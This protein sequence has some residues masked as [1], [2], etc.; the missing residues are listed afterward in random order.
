MTTWNLDIGTRKFR[1]RRRGV[2]IVEV[3]F[4]ILITTV[5]LFGA[6]AVFPFASAQARRARLFDM[7]AVAGRS[8]FHDF[9]ARGMRRP[10]M[11]LAWDQVNT[12]FVPAMGVSNKQVAESYCIDPRMIAAQT[13]Y[14]TAGV[15]QLLPFA[16][17][18]GQL[19]GQCV[20]YFPYVEPFLDGDKN[21]FRG[22]SENHADLNNNGNFDPLQFNP[23]NKTFDSSLMR[24]ITLRRSAGS[25]FPMTLPQANSIFKIDDDL[26]YDRPD[27]DKSLPA[28]QSVIPLSGALATVWG[29]RQSEGKIS[30][31]ATLVPKFDI[32]GVPG[33]EYVLSVVMLHDR[34]TDLDRLDHLRER[35]VMGIWQD[36]NAATGG[37]IQLR[38]DYT[39]DESQEQLKLKPNDWVMVS[40]TYPVAALGAYVTRYCWYRVSDC[41]PAPSAMK[42]TN[43]NII[44]YELYATL[45]GQDWNTNFTSPPGTYSGVLPQVRVTIVQGAFAVYEKTVRLDYGSTF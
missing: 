28:T 15:P 17:Y 6:I 27:E 1:S 2:T 12:S 10:D 5:G 13:T 19:G 26:A 11:W 21:S 44:G 35:V 9:D 36:T 29:K 45:M 30:W 22:T 43:G 31:L 20:Q 39:N 8:S 24:R 38:V 14:N 33:D 16:S 23:L 40:G 41:D 18:T 32:S 25:L 4:A 3:L 34:P 7:M 42:N 37:E